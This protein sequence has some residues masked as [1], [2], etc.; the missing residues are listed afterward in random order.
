EPFSDRYEGIYFVERHLY[1]HVCGHKLVFT[2][3]NRD[4]GLRFCYAW[5]S[6]EQ[7]GWIRRAWVEN[8]NDEAVSLE[9]I[10]G[11]QNILPSGVNLDMQ[12]RVS[13]L[14]DAYKKNEIEADTGLGIFS[15]S[16]IL[17]DKPEPS[18]SLQATTVWSAGIEAKQYLLSDRQLSAFRRGEQIDG[19]SDIRAERGAYFLHCE[20]S[21]RSQ[22]SQEW[23]MVIEGDQGPAQV[24]NLQQ[25]LKDKVYL[26]RQLNA[27]VAVGT[28]KLRRIVAQADGL[29]ATNDLLNVHRHYAN[30]MFN[31]MRGGIYAQQY[32]IEKADFLGFVQ[33]FNRKVYAQ[34]QGF[35]DGLADRFSLQNLREGLSQLDNPDLI[36]LSYEYLPLTFSRRHGDPSRP[37]NFFSIETQDE[38]G[39]KILNFQGNWRD[40]FQNWEALSVSYPD[41]VES[42]ICKFLNASTADGYNPYRITREGIDWEKTDPHDP[43]SFIGYWGDHQIIYLLKL[44]ELSVAHHPERLK[45][46]MQREIFAYANVPYRIRE[47][48]DIY[49]NPHDTILFD[50]EVESKIDQSVEAFGADGKLLLNP[51]QEVIH[52]NLLEKLLV[53]VLAKMSNFIPEA[54]IWLNT[55]RPEWNDANNA[56]VGNGVSM[57]TLYYLRRF[58]LFF[59]D[60]LQSLEETDFNISQEVG[61]LLGQLSRCFAE[62]Q[63]LLSSPIS[64]EDRLQ[65]VAELGKAGS[66]YREKIYQSGFS[67][68]KSALSKDDLLSWIEHSLAFIDHSI[69]AN[70]REDK[71]YHAYNLIQRKADSLGIRYLYEMLEGQVAILS[72]G[73]LSAEAS[74]TL[75][76]AMKESG[77]YRENQYSYMLYPNRQLPRFMAKNNVP[78]S[79]VSNSQLLQQMLA[80]GE[81]SILV[82]DQAGGYHFNGA[83]RNAA[84][85]QETIGELRQNGRS[86]SEEEATVILDIF[87]SVFDHQSFTG[88]SGTFFAYEGLGSIY[89]HMV[90]KLLLAIGETYLRGI[91]EEASQESLDRL[92]EH[93]YEV[94]AG[95]GMSKNPKLYGAFPTDP[96][97]HTPAHTGAQQPGMT[98]QV[99]EDIL[100]RF[101]ELG[102]FVSDGAIHF[103]PD[104]L[105]KAEFLQ[106]SRPFLWID[107]EGQEQILKLEPK[108]LA[109]TYCQIPV[110]YHLGDEAKIKLLVEGSDLV[111]EGH[112]ITAEHAQEVFTR[113]GKI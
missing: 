81:N 75:L 84:D 25:A 10:D 11:I 61:D 52:A 27:D 66:A 36:R 91:K 65:M 6:S 19:E 34:E 101:N 96:Y 7:W 87:E 26:L 2:E 93:Y 22:Q 49:R 5:E 76:D 90:S 33:H 13:T 89:W 111:I 104:L 78:A 109:F 74:V 51:E 94:R 14:V 85:L 98:G 59:R 106:D 108:S 23:V 58:Q 35:L 1:K 48:D 100:S 4:L 17:V 45:E 67:G 86:V 71:L 8:L 30:V 46:M 18:E 41:F 31:V 99:K 107:Q 80:E 105:R 70:E 20:L 39:Q 40:I 54:G 56:L 29:Q 73:Y 50:E 55:Q 92:V 38:E 113:S 37:W 15:L 79:A 28:Q 44:M 110:V 112:I 97:S 12:T 95:I 9:F 63:A 24:A 88:R 47:F 102:I 83:F 72:A 43:W 69:A 21:L 3:R 68:Q 57:V 62:R 82:Q 64:D 32:E 53:P 16:S 103:R 77:L 42:I 60:F